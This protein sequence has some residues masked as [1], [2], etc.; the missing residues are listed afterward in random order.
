[1]CVY[2]DNLQIVDTRGPI[3][4]ET[5]YYPPGLPIVAISDKAWNKQI[6]NYHFQGKEFQSQEFKNGFSLEQYDFHARFY[7]Q[8]LGVWHNQ[9]PAHQF[10]SPYLA[11]GDSWPNGTDMDGKSWLGDMFRVINGIFAWNNH[12][13]FGGN[14]WNIF[15]RSTFESG[16]Q[17]AGT[18]VALVSTT[19]GSVNSVDYFDGALVVRTRQLTED[20]AFTLGNT[21]IG[22]ND[23]L[24][25]DIHNPL[26]QHEY[27]RVLQSRAQG[28]TYFGRT[29]IPSLA[30]GSPLANANIYAQ[31][32]N[33]RSLA[34]FYKFHGGQPFANTWNF[35]V[36]QNG[37][38]IDHYCQ[39]CDFDAPVN[40]DA[41]KNA[42]RGPF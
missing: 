13:T 22:D 5:H 32:G 34:Y 17:I 24:N 16:Q 28:M 4:E 11:M 39:T 25:T 9:D 19:F 30:D 18:L 8:Q 27:G 3:L 14:L 6:N 12:R 1:V 20:R 37:N 15:S 2:F 23:F 42:E 26:L 21:I 10:A 29:A 40:Q 36:F 31:D 7:D 33:A 41:I 35:N 38:P